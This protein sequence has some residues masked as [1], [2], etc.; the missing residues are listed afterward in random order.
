[1]SG[2]KLKKNVCEET[3]EENCT[4]TRYAI[5]NEKTQELVSQG[6]IFHPNL[7]RILHVIAEVLLHTFNTLVVTA[8]ND[9]TTVDFNQ[10]VFLE[11]LAGSIV[12][13]ICKYGKIEDDKDLMRER[14]KQDITTII[15]RTG[16]ISSIIPSKEITIGRFI[17]NYQEKSPDLEIIENKLGL[18]CAK[19][20]I[21]ELKIEKN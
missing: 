10:D 8:M 21:V 1:M 9:P 12:F 16:N 7:R 14:L 18:S 15:Q 11:E 6:S 17:Y 4:K 13:V 19:L 20:R 3:K 2:G 5:K